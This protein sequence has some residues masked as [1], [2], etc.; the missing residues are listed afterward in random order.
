MLLSDTAE[1][2]AS[3]RLCVPTVLGFTEAAQRGICAFGACE[4]S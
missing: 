1:S 2:I 3:L 4:P